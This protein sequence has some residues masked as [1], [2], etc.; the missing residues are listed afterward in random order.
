VLWLV[1]PSGLLRR[2]GDGGRRF[3]RQPLPLPVGS[4]AVAGRSLVASLGWA[5]F[6]RPGLFLS[7]PRNSLAASTDRGRSW[8][9]V[10]APPA[11]RLGAVVG[12]SLLL[13]EGPAG[14]VLRAPLPV[15]TVRLVRP[16]RVLGRARSGR[17]L[18]CQPARFAG[19][20]L[21]S[22]TAVG[23]P[24][25]GPLAG[26]TY[27]IPRAPGATYACQTIARTPTGLVVASSAVVRVP[28]T[29]PGGGAGG[30]ASG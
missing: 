17:T 11:A 14:T 6:A 21:A 24:G 9:I 29:V 27:R 12:R 15:A 5:R 25:G 16:P 1:Q 28:G 2:S 22:T 3:G 18:R 8:T 7:L 20:V 26:A 19:R 13:A 23:I 10:D 4:L 30:E